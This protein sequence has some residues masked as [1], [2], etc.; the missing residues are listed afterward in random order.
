MAG[1]ERALR[2][3]GM[4]VLRD[5]GRADDELISDGIVDALAGARVLVA[6]HSRSGPLTAPRPWAL[7]TL[8]LAASRIRDPYRR[9]VVV[10]AE[11]DLAHLLPAELRDCVVPMPDDVAGLVRGRFAESASDPGSF[12]GRHRALWSLHHAL[13]GPRPPLGHAPVAVLCGVPGSGKTA[14]AQ[15][16]ATLFAPAF[17]GGT[18]RTGPFGHQDPADF[19]PQFHLALADALSRRFGVDTTGLTLARLG[20]LAADRIDEPTLVLVDD[21][22]AGL[23][24][25]VLDRIV[26]PSPLVSTLV[27]ARQAQPLWDTAT[28]ELTGL[29]TEDGLRLFAGVR[30]PADDHEREAVRR[31]VERCGGHPFA[32]RANALIVGRRAVALRDEVLRDRPD[33]APQAIRDVLDD[34]TPV[35]RRVVRLG[36]VL[37]PVPFPVAFAA[38][39]LGLRTAAITAAGTEL[40]HCGLA[41]PDDEEIR[42]HTLVLEVA[43]SAFPPARP[44]RHVT[45]AVLRWLR[46]GPG[47]HRVALLQ[48]A[49]ALAEHTMEARAALLRPV[50]AAWS[51]LGDAAA[52]G[53]VRAAI[54]SGDAPT[55][56]DYLEAARVETECALYPRAVRHALH[57]RTIA[58]DGAGRDEAALVAAQALDR[59]GNYAAADE[60]FWHT[61][62]RSPPGALHAVIALARSRRIRGRPDQALSLLDG[63][64]PDDLTASLQLERARNLQ[65]TGQAD[66]AREAAADVVRAYREQGRRHHRRCAEAE[67]AWAD[68]V[69]A[70]RTEGE[71]NQL[72]AAPR[73]GDDAGSALTLAVSVVRCRVLVAWGRPREALG[74][75]AATERTLV[76][77][78]GDGHQLGYRIRH[79][80]GSAHALLHEF[81]RQAE[82]LED[83]IGPQARD[84][85]LHHPETLESRLDLGTALALTGARDRA[86]GIVERAVAD[87]ERT[88]G[89]DEALL[90]KASAAQAALR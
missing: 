19:L 71:L 52:A 4:S 50:A 21:V 18:L 67:L 37:A 30:A 33:S 7:I 45:G 49:R 54:L 12:A 70:T 3:S 46:D 83:V 17:P 5:D 69:L 11:P 14:T 59:Q 35:A 25:A 1:I 44:H 68:S 86:T 62:L 82:I 56:G 23:P 89:V 26:L 28:I 77:V 8:F 74:V 63:T 55:A 32:L 6:V 64:R 58:D 81:D 43:R 16:Y 61:A 79:A 51:A 38:E 15:R 42:L 39:A 29:S 57:A 9:I 60:A 75:L 48:H 20:R 72:I 66:L 78:H 31:F 47:R 73:P 40:V 2:R 10:T 22:P 27:T 65:L 76:R 90:G 84:L 53:E 13:R 80:M 88:F 34:L 24:P 36:T 41:Q 85:G 87:L